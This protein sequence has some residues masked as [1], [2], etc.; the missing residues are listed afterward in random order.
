MSGQKIAIDQAKCTKLSFESAVCFKKN[1]EGV[2]TLS[3]FEIE[4]YTGAVVDR[5]WGKLAVAIDGISARQQMPIFKD[6]DHTKIVGYSTETVAAEAF[7]VKG[8][9]SQTTEAARE[10]MGLAAEGFP[11]QASIGVR[12]LTVLELR[13]GA[14]TVVNGQEVQGPAEVWLESEVFET[15]FVPLGADSST[16]VTVFAEQEQHRVMTPKQT[17]ELKT[18]NLET[19]K[20]D[21]PDLVAAIIQEATAGQEALLAAARDEGATAER[22]RI[23][24]VLAQ[25]IPGHERLIETLAFD[26]T[27][28]GPMA[29]VQVLAAERKLRQQ[30]LEQFKSEAPPPAPAAVVDGTSAKTPEQLAK[31]KWDGD[32]KLRAEFADQF[33]VYLAYRQETPGVRV[34]ST[35]RGEV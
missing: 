11:W 33:D 9:F 7:S 20:Q 21:F 6:H 1:P 23:T 25:S 34:K 14:A 27:T 24:E 5:W 28:T 3:G 18:M 15:S 29:A 32:P 13:E 4:A 10:V 2:S 19:L 17:E 16:R 22:Q 30:G 26:G 12:P 31:E 8:V 35:Q